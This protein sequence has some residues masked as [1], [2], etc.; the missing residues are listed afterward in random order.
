[1]SNK[2]LIFDQE[3]FIQ[4]KNALS[5]E[6]FA[7]LSCEY[8]IL[9]QQANAILTH[10]RKKNISLG[11]F[12]QQSPD[13]L[14]VVPEIHNPLEICRFE[15]IAHCSQKLNDIVI[16]RVKNIIDQLMGEPFVLFKDKCNVKNPGGGAFPPHQDI[17]AYHQFQPTFH[18][19]A[20]IILDASTIANGCLEM[21]T[22]YTT[23][24]KK[25]TQIL[26]TVFGPLPFFAFYQGGSRNGD[27]VDQIHKKFHWVPIQAQPGDVILFN[28]FVPHRSKTNTSNNSRRNFFFTFNALREGNWYESYYDLK[29]RDY[30]NPTF[31]V[32]TPTEHNS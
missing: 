16:H 22:Q 21:A 27:I 18:V 28:S 26:D 5:A 2:K 7:I 14:V 15:Y 3:G 29:R 4:I 17:T 20:A 31:H 9:Q 1:M 25:S 30:N 6:E 10:T 12:Y 8:D 23:H 24:M 32:S 19:T 11:E 13:Q